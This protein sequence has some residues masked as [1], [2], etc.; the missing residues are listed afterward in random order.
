M[1]LP[2]AA[3]AAALVSEAT[4]V[5]ARL[6]SGDRNPAL[7]FRGVFDSLLSWVTAVQDRFGLV[8]FNTLQRR[9][10][11]ALT[12]GT[13]FVATQTFSVGQTAFDFFASF[14]ITPVSYTHLD[15]YKRQALGCAAVALVLAGVAVM[16]WAVTPVAPVHAPW[17]LLGVPLLPLAVAVVCVWRAPGTDNNFARLTRQVEDDLAMLRAAASS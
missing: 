15:V 1:V 2:M 3:V 7:F 17:V 5:Y 4:L 8:S 14:F 11:A 9:L 6:Q 13:Q 16:L 12:Q 10:T